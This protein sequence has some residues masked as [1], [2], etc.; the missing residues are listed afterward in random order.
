[1]CRNNPPSGTEEVS[2][3]GFE[4]FGSVSWEPFSF[5]EQDLYFGGCPLPP[6]LAFATSAQPSFAVRSL[7][8][9]TN[10]ISHRPAYLSNQQLTAATRA[11]LSGLTCPIVSRHR[12]ALQTSCGKISHSKQAICTAANVSLSLSSS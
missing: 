3:D 5:S 2:T 1:M 8:N 4:R 12:H 10:C 7:H 11:R 6:N 9:C